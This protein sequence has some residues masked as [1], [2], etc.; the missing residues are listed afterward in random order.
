MITKNLDLDD[1]AVM[2]SSVSRLK[3]SGVRN[4]IDYVGFF[5][6]IVTGVGLL[7]GKSQVR[8]LYLVWGVFVISYQFISF[9]EKLFLV[10]G[11]LFFIL[12]VFILFRHSKTS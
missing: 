1:G 11:L 12:V 8:Y 5:V 6:M 10:P 2:S 3:P 4:V 7:F 9:P